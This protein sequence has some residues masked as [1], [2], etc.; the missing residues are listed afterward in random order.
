MRVLAEWRDGDDVVF[1]VV[2]VVLD[3]VIVVIC[4]GFD[5]GNHGEVWVIL[6]MRVGCTLNCCALI[7]VV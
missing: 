4:V 5:G 2:K 3:V 6:I 1:C 7:L